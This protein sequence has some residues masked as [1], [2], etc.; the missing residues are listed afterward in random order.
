MSLN[1]TDKRIQGTTNNRTNSRANQRRKRHNRNRRT[2]VTLTRYRPLTPTRLNRARV[3]RIARSKVNRRLLRMVNL[4]TDTN[5]SVAFVNNN[6]ANR[7]IHIRTQEA[8]DAALIKRGRAGVLNNLFGPTV[9]NKAI[10]AQTLAT[11]ASLRRSRRQ[12]IVI[13]IFKHNSRAMRRF[14]N[15]TIRYLT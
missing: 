8:A 10:R 13:R 15:F 1:N 2:T 11:K 6:G 3:L 9:K 4:N 12:R 7:N 14:S 5:Y